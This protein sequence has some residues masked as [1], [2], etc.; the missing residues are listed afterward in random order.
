M[1][2]HERYCP[3]HMRPLL[4][5]GLGLVCPEGVAGHAVH[6]WQVVDTKRHEALAEVTAEDGSVREMREKLMVKELP[7]PSI[8]G[9]APKAGTL[10][11]ARFKSGAGR[12]SIRLW[13]TKAG[14]FRVSWRRKVPTGANAGHTYSGAD[15]RLARQA[16]DSSIVA[17]RAKGWSEVPKGRQ[18]TLTE[19][20]PPPIAP[21]AVTGPRITRPRVS[22]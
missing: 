13:L 3:Q 15:Q 11:H 10:D 1:G 7:A 18:I 14:L 17:A 2:R 16:Y 21:R 5:V 8:G 22:R 19:I 20:P 9:I 6:R 12:L 4:T